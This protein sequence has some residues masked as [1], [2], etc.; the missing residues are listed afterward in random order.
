MIMF[1]SRG[2]IFLPI[3][4][5]CPFINIIDF[6]QLK[7]HEHVHKHWILL[8]NDT[9]VILEWYYVVDA[10]HVLHYMGT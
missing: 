6:R 7:L 10:I 8:I 4:K 5:Y 1:I 9:H 2:Q 3:I